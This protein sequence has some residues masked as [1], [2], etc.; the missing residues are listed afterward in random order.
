[1]SALFGITVVEIASIGPGPHAGMMLA[2][3]GARV[4]RVQRPGTSAGVSTDAQT[5]PTLRGR[6]VITADLKTADGR[7]QVLALLAQADVLIEGMRPGVT[8]RLGLGPSDCQQVNPRL[9]Y[10]RITGWGQTG[11]WANRAGHDLN[12]IG[13]TGALHAMGRADREPPVPLNLV[14]DYG[15]GSMLLV[16]GILAALLERQ[17]TGVGSV[18]DAAMI[19][20][21]AQLCQLVLGLMNAGQ[22]QD[23]RAANVLDGYAPFYDTYVCADGKYVAVAPLEPAFFAQLIAGLGLS[24]AWL[25]RQYDQA[26][27]PHLRAELAHAFKQQSRDHWAETFADTDACV[28]PV[29]SFTEAVAHPQMQ[30]RGVYQSHGSHLAAA[31]APRFGPLT[32]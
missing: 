32:G 2:D 9:V 18:V 14:G 27:W 7:D 4:I 31:P 22:W 29:L 24:E 25:A 23:V 21:T 15:G 26:G 11:P 30:A 16:V 13:L 17:R 20:G 19:D 8:E 5:D 1:M 12:Y 6:E 28:T 3:L 10:G